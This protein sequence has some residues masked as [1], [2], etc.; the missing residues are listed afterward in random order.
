MKTR[1]DLLNFLAQRYNLK[2]YLEIGVQN[3]A[4]NFNKIWCPY[5]LSVDPDP[6]AGASFVMTSDDFFRHSS[7]KTTEGEVVFDL[8]FIDGLH[9]A[10]QVRRD[11]FHST[12][13][14]SRNGFIVL[15]DCNPDME[16][17]TH[18]PRDSKIWFGDVYKFAAQFSGNPYFKTVDIDCGC[19]VFSNTQNHRVIDM[20][21]TWEAFDRN[22]KALLNL[23]SAEEFVRLHKE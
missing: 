15:H 4:N 17:H 8:V 14:L 12:K 13:I 3:P 21:I 19:G 10:D 18:V 11:F 5:K 23:V 7:S 2:R 22:R 20:E 6:E 9:H 16:E 1:T